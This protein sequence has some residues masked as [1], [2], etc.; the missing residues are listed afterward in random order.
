[1]DSLEVRVYVDPSPEGSEALRCAAALTA[2]QSR[3]A[4][5][6]RPSLW[7][8]EPFDL[9]LSSESDHVLP[10][11]W[12]R[13]TFGESLE[14]EWFVVGLLLQITAE[15]RD[16]SITACDS[17]GQFLLIEAA[18]CLPA[19]LS[20]EKAE[21]RV[22]L[23]QGAVH[24]I[25]RS[26]THPL[27]LSSALNALRS[28]EVSTLS[29]EASRAIVARTREL[30][31]GGVARG[32]PTHQARCLLPLAAAQL[33]S[34]QPQLVSAAVSSFLDRSSQAMRAAARMAH[35][36][37]RIQPELMAAVAFPRCR[38]A[39]LIAQ[40]FEPPPSSGFRQLAS[41]HP[42]AKAAELGA[43][44][45]FGL[46]LLL[47]AADSSPQRGEGETAGVAP[48][49]KQANVVASILRGEGGGKWERFQ[50]SLV[51]RGYFRGEL[52]GSRLYTQLLEQAAREF[53]RGE[54]SP[55]ALSWL[56]RDGLRA[57]ALLESSSSL[58]SEEALRKAEE[59]AC[60]EPDDWM[61]LSES[62]LNDRLQ[63][64]LQPHS[65]ESG[66]DGLH[67]LEGVVQS[68]G[69]FVN[70]HSGPDGAE[71]P[72]ALDPAVSFDPNRFMAVLAE[73]LG[74]H[75]DEKLFDSKPNDDDDDDDDDEVVES[76]EDDEDEREG[77]GK[78][79]DDIE[80]VAGI[81]DFMEAMDLE[82][83]QKQK[84]TDFELERTCQTGIDPV[85]QVNDSQG[86]PTVSASITK[87]TTDNSM[88]TK[89]GEADIEEEY[90]PV[91][92]DLNLV[93]NLLASYSSQHGLAGP[94][95][96]LLGTMGLDLPDDDSA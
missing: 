16:L 83:R 84:G 56:E 36:S 86:K 3:L 45:A 57:R 60:D 66:S 42:D 59:V 51:M 82:L 91:D 48:L 31:Q 70:S 41:T 52:E 90:Q 81:K 89:S 73:A 87:G 64:Y 40:P 2:L 34:A 69:R 14:D 85:E 55:S 28:E 7:H 54:S 58:P 49:E 53:V 15:Q 72:K 39:Q 68:V 24:I 30:Q 8:C 35:F 4:P 63:K 93:K 19:W 79:E 80:G 9:H 92:L 27:P 46:E 43:K 33:L 11:L 65:R 12:A 71:V 17:D 76:D 75:P 47:H 38:Y 95:S 88:E 23:R 26:F 32:P 18:D 74:E 94:V 61:Y 25:P 21:N 29:P 22:F 6:L 78:P 13:M 96:N 1:M 10:H 20:P 5:R 62:S 77:E 67:G 44:L 37:P 50:E